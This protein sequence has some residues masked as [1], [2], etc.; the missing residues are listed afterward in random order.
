MNIP[1]RLTLLRVLMVPAFVVVLLLPSVS[2][3]LALALF[4]LAG[5]T[6]LLDGAIARKKNMVTD[7][8]KL[9]DP[10]ADKLMLTAAL[11]CF[12]YAGLVHP[13]VTII[14]ISREL[15]VTGLRTLAISKGKVIAADFW[16]KLKTVAQDVTIIVILVWQSCPASAFGGF[17]RVLSVL[18]IW[19]MLVLTVISAIHYCI[20]NKEVFQNAK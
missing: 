17:C 3:W 1:N 13:A 19:A 8:G 6:D 11:V 12:T 9:M 2:D 14:V 18:C 4:A 16:G 5:L 15:L 20:V 10:L 7:F